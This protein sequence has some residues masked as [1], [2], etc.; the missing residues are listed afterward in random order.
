MLIHCT[1]LSTKSHEDAH[2]NVIIR[3][4]MN[5]EL[6]VELSSHRRCL[7]S[8]QFKTASETKKTEH[9]MIDCKNCLSWVVQIITVWTI[10]FQVSLLGGLQFAQTKCRSC[11]YTSNKCEIDVNIT[12]RKF[13][14]MMLMIGESQRR[15]LT[16]S[17][18]D[19]IIFIMFLW[20][21]PKS[22]S[23]VQMKWLLDH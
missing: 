10:L 4:L 21:L 12:R 3:K 15:Q 2:Q 7:S 1:V 6:R 8:T 14:I 16:S 9:S 13:I 11:A 22:F 5:S 20:S 19:E 18:I 17:V 23:L